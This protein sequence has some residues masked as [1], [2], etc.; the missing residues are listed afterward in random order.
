[1]G[2][3]QFAP[4]KIR[5]KWAV[6][7]FCNTTTIANH[8]VCGEVEIRVFA[9]TKTSFSSNCRF[10]ILALAS[11]ADHKQRRCHDLSPCAESLRVGVPSRQLEEMF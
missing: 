1:M 10:Q 3:T 6:S 2:M 7:S 8:I 9:G 5:P 4:S 11:E